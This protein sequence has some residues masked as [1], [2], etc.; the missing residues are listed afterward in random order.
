VNSPNSS[1]A[2]F[3]WLVRD[4]PTPISNPPSQGMCQQSNAAYPHQ[5]Y[6]CKYKNFQNLL[7]SFFNEKKEF[8]KLNFGNS[9]FAKHEIR[10]F[11]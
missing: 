8:E 3:S 2:E 4:M 7:K 9:E 6:I 10:H 1:F 11:P 5:K